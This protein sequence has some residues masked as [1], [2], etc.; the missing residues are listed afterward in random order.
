MAKSN[1]TP[2]AIDADEGE[3]PE[4]ELRYLADD[5][6][7]G[8]VDGVVVAYVMGD[9]LVKYKLMGALADEENL[10]NVANIV[11]ELKRRIHTRL[12][13]SHTRLAISS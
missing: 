6:E 5:Y 1:L 4:V 11:G 7:A 2:R 9:G 13:L 10:D 3:A 8:A 12:A